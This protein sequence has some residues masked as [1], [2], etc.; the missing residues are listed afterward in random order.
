MT[1][2]ANYLKSLIGTQVIDLNMNRKGFIRSIAF[3][4][5]DWKIC[6]FNFKW[7]HGEYLRQIDELK[8]FQPK[9]LS[10]EL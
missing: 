10:L 7:E 9:Q 5:K 1:N 4:S 8:I 3:H 6:W 2:E